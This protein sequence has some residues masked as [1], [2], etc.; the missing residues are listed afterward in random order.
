MK[1]YW[2]GGGVEVGSGD[3]ATCIP[4]LSDRCWRVVR[5]ALEAF[6]TAKEPQYLLDARVSG[7]QSHSECG[8]EE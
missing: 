7:P 3:I 6:A 5:Y 8:R 1:I 2:M 4:N